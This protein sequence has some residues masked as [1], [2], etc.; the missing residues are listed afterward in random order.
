M[1]PDFVLDASVAVA[2]CFGDERNQVLDNLEATLS[3]RTA[4]VPVHWH[5]EVLNALYMTE[6]RGRLD[7]ARWPLLLKQLARYPLA[8]D[9]G[10]PAMTSR[11]ALDLARQYRLTVYDAAYLELALRRGLPLASLDNALVAAARAAGVETLL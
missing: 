10:L 5:G 9:D 1:L 4:W 2:W 11:A 3:E 8:D 7:P 6:R